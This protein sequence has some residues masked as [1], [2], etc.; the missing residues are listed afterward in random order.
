MQRR[1]RW[2]NDDRTHNK[3]NASDRE[4]SINDEIRHGQWK[5]R[6]WLAEEGEGELMM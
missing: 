5:E 6:K 1:Q 2:R 3:A 4:Q